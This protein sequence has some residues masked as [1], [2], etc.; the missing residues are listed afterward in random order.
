MKKLSLRLLIISFMLSV[1]LLAGCSQQASEVDNNNDIDKAQNGQEASNEKENNES[2][3]NANDKE[4]EQVSE[5]QDERT[6]VIGNG[7]E[8]ILPPASEINKFITTSVPIPSSYLLMGGDVDKLVGINPG[9]KAESKYSILFKISP[10]LHNVADS[11]MEGQDVN[12][13]EM[14]KLNPDLVLYYG[15]FTKQGD[16]FK[17]IGIPTIDTKAKEGSDSIELMM[18][19]IKLLGEVFDLEG[20]EEINDYAHA[21]KDEIHQRTSNIEEDKKVKSLV[22]FRI[23]EKGIMVDGKGMQGDDWIL[24]SGAVNAAADVNGITNA[25]MEQIYKWNPDI[26]YIFNN[27]MP[28]DLI[29]NTIEGQD[30]SQIKAVQNGRVYKIPT[31]TSRWFPANTDTPLMMKWMA[32]L[33][34][35]DLFSDFDMEQELRDYYKKFFNYDISDEDIIKTLNPIREE[36]FVGGSGKQM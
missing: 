33:N 14:L 15:G 13:E 20:F 6:I 1:A 34:Y 31:G 22:L 21:V 16:L 17:S 23:S 29:N 18:H 25:N 28:E 3:Q 26:I 32:K 5:N 36:I 2:E 27:G 11:F 4:T 9:S 30:W 35:P 19:R 24:S 12:V 7:D 10:E 8:V